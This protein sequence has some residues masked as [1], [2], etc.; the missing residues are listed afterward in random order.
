MKAFKFLFLTIT[1]IAIFFVSAIAQ[2]TPP[3]GGGGQIPTTWIG[4]LTAVL[5]LLATF[6]P[7][8]W[9]K[10]TALWDK[11]GGLAEIIFGGLTDILTQIAEAGAQDVIYE[12]KLREAIKDGSY[13]EEERLM[14]L[15][16][17]NKVKKEQGDVKRSIQKLLADLRAYSAKKK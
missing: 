3:D 10:V 17:W 16:E 1:I 15:D 11:F 13:T 8:L 4:I 9:K 2:E 12:K 5:G 6:F 14:V 7:A